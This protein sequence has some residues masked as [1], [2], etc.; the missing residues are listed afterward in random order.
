MNFK[1]GVKVTLLPI[2]FSF[3]TST[4]EIMGPK[5]SSTKLRAIVDI[6]SVR[7]SLVSECKKQPPFWW[8][9]AAA[10]LILYKVIITNKNLFLCQNVFNFRNMRISSSVV[11]I[12]RKLP[13]ALDFFF[14]LLSLFYLHFFIVFTGT[15]F[16]LLFRGIF[17]WFA[18]IINVHKTS[19]FF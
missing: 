12:F 14:F 10:S 4:Y 3:Y 7:H 11:T 18:H 6:R 1:K 17:F 13:L 9:Q 19:F 5:I 8:Q 15:T 2:S 16:A